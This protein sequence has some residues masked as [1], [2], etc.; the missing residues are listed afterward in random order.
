MCQRGGPTSFDKIFG[1]PAH[2]A[3]GKPSVHE[4]FSAFIGDQLSL[5]DFAEALDAYHGI[6]LTAA[7]VQLL[8]STDANSGR[9]SFQHFQRALQEGAAAAG[10]GRG[11][12]GQ[13]SNFSDQAGAIITDNCGVPAPKQPSS[14]VKVKT[15]ISIDPF[16][17]QQKRME[18]QRQSKE[19]FTDNPVMRSNRPSPGNPMAAR[20]EA[21]AA[22]GPEQEQEGP[23]EMAQTATRMFVSGELPCAEFER[24]VTQDLGV[25]LAAE[26]SELRRLITAHE[27]VGGG[28]FVPL[29]RA[30][31]REMASAPRCGGDPDGC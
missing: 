31:L 13:A 9:L 17:K 1:Q 22:R 20:L 25:N 16:V 26:D 27:K 5:P 15:D 24:F 4:L 19:P 29:S 3:D 10:L 12:A 2:A 18:N 30:V 14:T 21:G 11:G 23:R 7:A 28:S 8:S 6:Q